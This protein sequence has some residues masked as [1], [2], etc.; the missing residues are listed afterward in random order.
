MPTNRRRRVRPR[1]P[2][3]YSAI[4]GHEIIRWNI[5]SPVV[6]DFTPAAGVTDFA[7]NSVLVWPSWD[8]LFNVYRV[9]REEY[10]AEFRGRW[11]DRPDPG[12]EVQYELYLAGRDPYTWREERPDLDPRQWLAKA[13]AEKGW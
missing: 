7:L 11:P 10:L 13:L 12:I 3:Q 1:Y 5:G 9:C 4:P 8:D 6:G 2:T